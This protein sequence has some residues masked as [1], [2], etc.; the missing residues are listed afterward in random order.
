M[1]K[2]LL[3]LSA[4]VILMS[5]QMLVA[6]QGD[7]HRLVEYQVPVMRMGYE[8]GYIPKVTGRFVN[9]RKPI[10]D[11]DYLCKHKLNDTNIFMRIPGS[12]FAYHRISLGSTVAPVATLSCDYDTMGPMESLRLANEEPS[13]AL[14]YFT[15]KAEITKNLKYGYPD[16]KRV[17]EPHA[18]SQD[19]KVLNAG[20]FIEGRP[21]D[22]TFCGQKVK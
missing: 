8:V 4:I 18:V 22:P 14:E 20:L 2:H 6:A 5:P 15:G 19:I 17:L 7:V 21:F 13:D 10:F 11:S 9:S 3:A 16:G 1:A 12:F